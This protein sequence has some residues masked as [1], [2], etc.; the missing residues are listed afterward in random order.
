M[1]LR[2][3]NTIFSRS[4][5]K[6]PDEESPLGRSPTYRT[7]LTRAPSY[8]THA[9][10][11]SRSTNPEIDA[12]LSVIEEMSSVVRT[13]LPETSSVAGTI[14]EATVRSGPRYVYYRLYTKDGAIESNNAIYSNDR[15]LGR[16]DAKDVA[17]PYTV[18]FL[19]NVLCR[20]EG[21]K[22]SDRSNLYLSVP[23]Y[24]PME[25]GT[26]LSLTAQSGP[27]LYEHE[28]VVLVVDSIDEREAVKPSRGKLR[29]QTNV[30]YVHYR[31]YSR[32]GAIET[33]SSNTNDHFLGRIFPGSVSPP[34]TAAS[35]KAY[36]CK[37]EDIP[38]VENATLYVALSSQTPM[39]DS[40]HL[41]LLGPSGPG[42]S[43]HEPMALVVSSQQRPA[44]GLKRPL[45]KYKP[46]HNPRYVY[47]RL[48]TK[49]GAAKSRTFF[50]KD[51]ESLGRVDIFFVSPP[52]ILSSLKCHIATV[53]GISTLDMQLYEEGSND[54]PVIDSQLISLLASGHNEEHPLAVVCVV[55]KDPWRAYS[56]QHPTFTKKLQVTRSHQPGRKSWLDVKA[57]EVLL[58]DGV[59]TYTSWS[60][61]DIYA[62]Y[63]YTA[64][65]SAGKVGFVYGACV[66]P[67][68][69]EE[70]LDVGATAE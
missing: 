59:Q 14:R 21:F 28:P 3:L 35:L 31:L 1:A 15:S 69:S 2:R 64:V 24:M 57:G 47:Y 43:E 66:N 30:R 52:H 19:K 61:G 39:E 26:R 56:L 36:L 41:S 25:D 32:E 29:T 70:A 8:T 65:N 62:R 40:T 10:G 27:G 18:I 67:L 5:R 13:S 12:N 16:I 63:G 54:E 38:S 49:D 46:E 50:N 20:K 22:T 68:P 11:P 51:D 23:S 48:Y 58:T 6:S 33:N 37:I 55:N 4:N 9:A 44:K 34:H 42:L 7:S 45:K 60:P 53:E 17:P